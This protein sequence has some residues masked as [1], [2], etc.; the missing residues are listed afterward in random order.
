MSMSYLVVLL[1]PSS[2]SSASMVMACAGQ[3]ASHSLQA[4]QRSSPVGYLFRAHTISGCVL[5]SSSSSSSPGRQIRLPSQ[6]VFATEP[7]TDGTL[8][9]GVVDGVW[10][11]EELFEDN[12]HSSHHLG[13]QEVVSNLVHGAFGLF[14]PS[15]GGSQTV[16]LWWRACGGCGP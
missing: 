5:L 13:E 12:V 2:R 7:R 1:E 11:A 16:A 3:M 15:L 8:L 10:W 14:I 4:M 6:C 9:E